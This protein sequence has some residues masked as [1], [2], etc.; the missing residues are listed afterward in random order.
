MCPGA[1]TELEGSASIAVRFGVPMLWI[2]DIEVVGT[3]AGTVLTHRAY[4]KAIACRA[5]LVDLARFPPF[6]VCTGWLHNA[7]WANIVT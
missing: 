1:G 7:A 3:D 4:A 5:G 2:G 6:E